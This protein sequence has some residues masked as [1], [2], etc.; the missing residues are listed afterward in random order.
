M[1]EHN[2]WSSDNFDLKIVA[3]SDI[4]DQKLENLAM[5]LRGLLYASMSRAHPLINN[6]FFSHRSEDVKV[7][8][9]EALAKE[10][11]K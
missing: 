5:L 3:R 9:P 6:L 1:K 11:T 10:S 7:L 2:F 4:P 8:T